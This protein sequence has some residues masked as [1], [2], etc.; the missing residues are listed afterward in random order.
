MEQN[1]FETSQQTLGSLLAA[2]LNTTNSNTNKGTVMSTQIE[3]LAK[4]LINRVRISVD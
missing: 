1:S 4:E 3:T 2:K